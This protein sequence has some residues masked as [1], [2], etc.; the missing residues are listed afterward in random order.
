MVE[1]AHAL[2]LAVD[3]CAPAAVA[4]HVLKAEFVHVV[5]GH[6]VRATR[7]DCQE[8][9]SVAEFFKRDLGGGRDMLLARHA[10]GERAVNIEEQVFAV[11][12]VRSFRFGSDNYIR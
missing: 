9:A 6:C 7:R 8:V 11:R 3:G 12:H 4:H 5:Y 10:R 2:E 1:R